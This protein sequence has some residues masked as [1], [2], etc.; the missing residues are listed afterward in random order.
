MFMLLL[1]N[2]PKTKNCMETF[3]A[4]CAEI[5]CVVQGLS[6]CCQLKACDSVMLKRPNTSPDD[7]ILAVPH[8]QGGSGLSC[9]RARVQQAQASE[10][11]SAS[12]ISQ[13]NRQGNWLPSLK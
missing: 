12:S 10:L 9:R 8:L 3:S 1:S 11:L 2:N 5:H 7:T 13:G 4:R 6:W